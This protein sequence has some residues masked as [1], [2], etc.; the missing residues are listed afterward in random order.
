M[1][2]LAALLLTVP[3]VAAAGP[4]GDARSE[5]ERALHARTPAERASALGTALDGKDSGETADAVLDLVVARDEPQAVLEVGLRA[6]ARMKDPAVLTAVEKAAAAGPLRQRACAIEV[7]GRA[8]SPAA[9]GPL[10][11]LLADPDAAVRTAAATALARRADETTRGN[12]EALLADPVWTVRSAASYALARIGSRRSIPALCAAMRPADGRSVDDCT[13]ALRTITGQR[14]GADPVRYLQWYARQEKLELSPP[15]LFEAPPASFRSL[16]AATRSRRILFVLSTAETMKDPVSGAAADETVLGTVRE[17]GDD[18]ARDLADAK[19]KLDVARVHLRAML[20]TLADGVAFDV[21]AYSGSPAFAFGRL[22]PA[23]ADSRKRAE[24]RI[25]SLSPGGPA[26]LH[27]ALVRAFDPRG[28]D[29]LAAEDG[30]DTIV[31]LTDGALAAPGSTDVAEVAQSVARWNAVRQVRFLVVGVGQCEEDL[32]GRLA[33]G[34]P[35]GA[36]AHLP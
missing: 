10:L 25:A 23:G 4:V 9:G 33:A 35:E 11:P 16:V 30:P 6:L 19:T 21:C 1:R 26:N 5:I 3:A 13:L 7:L 24:A 27:G 18:L 29:P 36:A 28:R 32:I 14:F 8:V 31:L 22:T 20:R 12:V 34:P 2:R 15:P 17:A